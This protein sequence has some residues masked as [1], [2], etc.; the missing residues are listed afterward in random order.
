M[1]KKS[2]KNADRTMLNDDDNSRFDE[3]VDTTKTPKEDREDQKRKEE[4]RQE[5]TSL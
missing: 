2:I 3:S 4:G 1:T 5:E